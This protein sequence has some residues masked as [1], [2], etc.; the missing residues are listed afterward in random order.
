MKTVRF[1]KKDQ[2]QF[3]SAL[4]KNV[5]AYFKENSI[6]MKG[7]WRMLPKSIAMLSMYLL[8]W[9]LMIVLPLPVWMMF[10]LS[11]IMGVGMAGI[12]MGVMHDAIHGS[13]SSSN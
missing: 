12:G 5:N 4:R 6:S 9:I 8:P 3:A 2:N 1:T 10:P 7:N 13:F 11:I